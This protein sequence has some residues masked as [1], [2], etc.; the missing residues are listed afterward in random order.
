[1]VMVYDEEY[2]AALAGRFGNSARDSSD[3][4]PEA[5]ATIPTVGG[6]E[7]LVS[8]AAGGMLIGYG[9]L[10]RNAAGAALALAGTALVIHGA[11]RRST[12]YDALGLE[13]ESDRG[14]WD[15]GLSRD[16]RARATMTINRNADDLYL[17]WLDLTRQP[18]YFRYLEQVELI[19]GTRSHWKARGPLGKSI[20]WDADLTADEP[21]RR[22]AWRSL[23]STLF[24]HEGAA[25]FEAAPPRRGTKVS[26][27]LR[28]NP[29][30][31]ALGALAARVLPQDPQREVREG[32]RRFKQFMETGE[33][34]T[35]DI[36]ATQGMT[37]QEY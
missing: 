30:A 8:A 15:V 5:V 32:L 29:P 28:W 2:G 25:R 18:R 31:G 33:L 34:A 10:R 20:E 13:E 16:V 17:E 12:F 27:E 3:L 9:L 19:D 26:L 23:N 6:A 22:I 37:Q 7:R 21:G 4:A 11:R 35:G 36:R 14:F 1:M 24:D